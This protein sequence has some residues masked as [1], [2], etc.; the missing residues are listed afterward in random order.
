MTSSSVF[1]NAQIH[2]DN[3]DKYHKEYVNAL[4]NLYELHRK[5][6][7][8]MKRTDSFEDFASRFEVF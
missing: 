5:S 3:V 1:A 4:R 7:H 2:E 6:F 8:R